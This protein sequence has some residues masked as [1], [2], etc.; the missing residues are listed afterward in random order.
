ML[1]IYSENRLR[2]KELSCFI[3]ESKTVK[4]E[5]NSWGKLQKATE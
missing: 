2:G 3:G 5:G 1:Y 4:T